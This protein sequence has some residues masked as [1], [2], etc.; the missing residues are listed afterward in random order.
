MVHLVLDGW[1]AEFKVVSSN[2]DQ[3]K[4]FY[5]FL[6]HKKE[7][8]IRLCDPLKKSPPI[9]FFCKDVNQFIDICLK[10]SGSWQIYAGLNERKEGGKKDEDVKTI[11][12]IGHDIDC[13]SEDSKI[14]VAGNQVIKIKEDALAQGFKEPLIFF[15]G[16]GYW[17]IHK[18]S[19]EKNTENL[20][21]IKMFAEKIK[22]RY[23]VS[24]IEFD[25]KVYN[26]SRIARVPGTL[27]LKDGKAI[28]SYTLNNPKAD[29]DEELTK[30][31]ISIDLPKYNNF[32]PIETPHGCKFMD[33]CLTHQMPEGQRHNIISRNMAIYV[34]KKS[35]SNQLK[36][37]YYKSQKGLVG[38]IDNWLSTIKKNPN[39]KYPFSCGE[40]VKY[41]RR[42]N[43]PLQCIGCPKFE[44]YFDKL[45]EKQKPIGWGKYLSIKE[46]AEKNGFM[47]C[48]KC[49]TDF[50]FDD[51]WAFFRC[52]SCNVKG[53]LKAFYVLMLMNRPKS[54][55]DGIERR[56]GSLPINGEDRRSKF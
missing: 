10:Y 16:G 44:E 26:P 33:Y 52:P 9:S 24:G 32:I 45:K 1:E 12:C 55:W 8:E 20:E 53:G 19:I 17:V 2:I 25:T 50:Y 23:E 35:N 41:Q 29:T 18:V 36:K 11:T 42:H 22:K 13:H 34:H 21:R 4:Q 43:L 31:I 38:D 37:M 49:K 14:E 3:I 47:K 30:S 27:N 54:K 28:L 6:K 46:I 15:S 39:R 51:R 56:K 5:E 48:P 40:L 7:T